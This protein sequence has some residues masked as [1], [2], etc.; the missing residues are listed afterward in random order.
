[1]TTVLLTADD[2]DVST[3]VLSLVL[4][5]FHDLFLSASGT[6]GAAQSETSQNVG[7]HVCCAFRWCAS[8]HHSGTSSVTADVEQ[9][10]RTGLLSLLVCRGALG[11][12]IGCMRIYMGGERR[13]TVAVCG[14][15]ATTRERV[16]G[17]QARCFCSR[18][19]QCAPCHR[20]FLTEGVR[21]TGDQE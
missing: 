3:C 19:V 4:I 20:F 10:V 18:K 12:W 14:V 13:A 17:H 5:Q 11:V 21:A 16:P 1:M 15:W 8:G 6:H 9:T 2:G 7:G